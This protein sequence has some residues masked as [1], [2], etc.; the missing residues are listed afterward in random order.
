[1]NTNQ[2]TGIS[3]FSGKIFSSIT[4][5][6]DS[7]DVG[8]YQAVVCCA[9]PF[10]FTKFSAVQLLSWNFPEISYQES[11]RLFRRILDLPFVFLRSELTWQY[12]ITA[13]KVLLEQL[14]KDKAKFENLSMNYIGILQQYLEEFSRERNEPNM[15]TGKSKDLTWKMRQVHLQIAYHWAPIDPQKSMKKLLEISDWSS[16]Q[17]KYLSDQK[18]AT[19][20]IRTNGQYFTS[21]RP[22][23]IY[24]QARYEYGRGEYFYAV[25]AE[26]FSHVFL[27]KPED[28]IIYCNSGHL[29]GVI[30]RKRGNSKATD[31]AIRVLRESLDICYNKIG[32]NNSTGLKMAARITNSLG[33]TLVK[34]NEKRKVSEGLLI[35]Q[36]SLEYQKKADDDFGLVQVL[37]SIGSAL[38]QFDNEEEINE[39]ERLLR[40]A[41]KLCRNIDSPKSE[42][43]LRVSL[44]GVLIRKGGEEN[45]EEATRLLK[46]C[47]EYAEGSHN[48]RH[49]AI[50]R[51]KIASLILAAEY[52]DRLIEAEEHLVK[53][54][55]F[56]KRVSHNGGTKHDL[57]A[58]AIIFDL[59][60]REDEA[61][62]TRLEA[63]EIIV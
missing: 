32:I 43:M 55:E 12:S 15:I 4:S 18:Q 41:L 48:E 36:Q 40:E 31:E 14:K 19:T 38:Q 46:K 25:A 63:E 34:S 58:L 60:G 1:M 54:I 5:L 37:N 13:R 6:V 2:S 51:S 52:K 44:S 39:A 9:L 57:E 53:S 50:T 16:G 17:K 11:E 26:K 22:E 61:D 62:L 29:L 45:F 30:L 42:S 35:L 28:P 20:I 23:C 49:E 8:L 33:A 56:W 27:M 10:W 7:F 21:L 24:L 3:D 47:L 59:T